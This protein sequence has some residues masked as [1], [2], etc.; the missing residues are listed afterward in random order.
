M[1][2]VCVVRSK[3]SFPCPSPLT[4]H[5]LAALPCATAESG[6]TY[7]WFWGGG[8]HSTNYLS[9]EGSY[10]AYTD[11][12]WPLDVTANDTFTWDVGSYSG[13]EEGFFICMA[14]Y[15]PPPPYSTTKY[16]LHLRV[17]IDGAGPGRGGGGGAGAVASCVRVK[18]KAYPPTHGKFKVTREYAIVTFAR[19]P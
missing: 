12:L 18:M 3:A 6:Y 19:V 14:H 11:N 15:A 7:R 8:S 5:S 16:D 4:P 1:S 13:V 2:Q 17:A 9:T 10:Y